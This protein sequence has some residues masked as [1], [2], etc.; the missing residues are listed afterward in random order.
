MVLSFMLMSDTAYFIH[1][2]DDGH[3]GCVQVFVGKNYAALNILVHV[4][5]GLCA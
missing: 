5:W 3:L 1:S 2:H 4:S